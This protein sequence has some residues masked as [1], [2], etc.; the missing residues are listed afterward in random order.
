MYMHVFNYLHVPT[1]KVVSR[2][3]VVNRVCRL[4]H[5]CGIQCIDCPQ[6]KDYDKDIKWNL[7]ITD[8]SG[9][10]KLAIYRL[11]CPLYMQVH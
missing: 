3:T 9:T 11:F 5:T 7:G 8:T 6:A 4:N 2:Y 1:L 10:T